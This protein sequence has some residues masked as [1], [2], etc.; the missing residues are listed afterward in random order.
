MARFLYQRVMR[1]L[2][3]AAG[4]PIS[5]RQF[6]T[7]TGAAS[8]GFLLSDLRFAGAQ[9][10]KGAKRVVVIGGGFSGLACA[11]ELKSVGYD[12]TIV[13]ARDRVGGRVLSFTDFVKDRVCEGGGELIGSNHPT[14]MNYAKKFDLEFLDVSED[15]DLES[16][17]LLDG[18]RVG[19]EEAE[20]AVE[21]GER[22]EEA[23]TVAAE[24]IN[25]DEPWTSPKADE[26][27]RMSLA[28]VINKM[29]APP[30]AKRLFLLL[31]SADNGV[32]A[33]RQ[34]YLGMLSMVRGGGGATFWSDTEVYRCK[35]GNSRL[36]GKLLEAIG[37]D[38]VVLNLPVTD[39][40]VRG[41]L[42][43]VTCSDGRTLTADDV[44][45]A[46]PPSVWSKIRFSPA[47]PGSL[48]P[49]MGVNTKYLAHTR[50]RF[51]KSNGLSQYAISDGPV[52]ETWESTDAQEGDDNA[53][54]VGFSGATYAERGLAQP[55]DKAE[56]F[57]KAE[58]EKLYPGF[59]EQFVKG[60]FM[61][62]PRDK[63]VMAS[64]SFPAPGQVTTIGPA[65]RK[66]L[67]RV[68]FAGEHC[69]YQFVGY[70]EGGLHAGVN[71]ARR[72]AKRDGVA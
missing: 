19:A 39:V 11:H 70:M 40:A 31:M 62:W 34:S 67:G 20:A 35:G 6:L 29:D 56:E 25:A 26:L 24:E 54:M 65:L 2:R 59:S 3:R 41:N 37:T 58:F 17:I 47:L 42:V 38:R 14:W 5:R 66:G 36:A 33:D 71:A 30:L 10:A 64:Y 15:A 51:W 22:I 60:R 32:P 68:H 45:L 50:S 18:K 16:P 48:S 46:V 28:E 9:P 49:Q 27:D 23:L 72:I 69:C 44:V 52:C 4:K 53:V 55:R 1:Q 7:A 21:A 61:D 12:V 57:F 8:A 13:E 63:W 43:T